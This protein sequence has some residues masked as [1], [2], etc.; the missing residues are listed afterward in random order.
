MW[1]RGFV[2]PVLGL[3]VGVRARLAVARFADPAR[4][5][6]RGAGLRPLPSLLATGAVYALAY[7]ALTF[8]VRAA[9]QRPAGVSVL[10]AQR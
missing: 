2:C 4:S 1:D 7:A 3:L 8:V 6:V 9:R 10:E 5:T